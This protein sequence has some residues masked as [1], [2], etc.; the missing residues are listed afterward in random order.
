M[1]SFAYP[2][3][4]V[5]RRIRINDAECS[6]VCRNTYARTY[7]NLNAFA[8]LHSLIYDGMGRDDT[9]RSKSETIA[10]STR[11]CC[12]LGAVPAADADNGF[13]AAWQQRTQMFQPTNKAGRRRKIGSRQ[14]GVE[15][16]LITYALPK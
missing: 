1:N 6:N 11:E 8:E 4:V 15:Q 13:R 3:L 9:A 7:Q 10:Q 14:R 16:D 5:N 2:A 12:P